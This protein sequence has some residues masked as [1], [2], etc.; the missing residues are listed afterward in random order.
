M[1][2]SALRPG[3]EHA[4]PRGP[5]LAV[6]AAPPAAPIARTAVPAAAG[7]EVVFTFSY[8]SWQAAA[9]RGWFMP[10][11][12]LA[13]ALVSHERVERVLIADLMRSL[14]A[15]LVR[16]AVSRARGDSHPFPAREGVR[17]ASPVRLRRAYPVS[18]P[19]VERAC[20]RYERALRRNAV[21]MGM[22]RPAVITANPLLA[23]FGR[24]EWA[25][26]VTFFA[27]DDWLAYP[28]HERWWPAYEESF[29]LVR[30]RGR[31]VC[32]VTP[33]A[34]ERISP[35]GP[36][37]VVP[38]GLDP[39]EWEGPAGAPPAWAREA[40]RPLLLYVGSLD[41]RLDIPALGA[42]A[43]ALPDAEIALVGPLLDEAHL[44]PLA[45]HANVSI[46]PP[47]GREEVAA[48]IRHADVGLIPHVSSEL[49][50]A[51]SPLKL[52]EY[53][54]GGLP[55]VAADLGPV[56]GVSEGVTLVPPGGGYA[57]G[58]K[59]ALGR[60]RSAEEE[61]LAFIAANSWRARQDD[62]LELALA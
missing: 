41:S 39:Q 27:T 51:M 46:H 34:L 8:V 5:R 2:D 45:A 57:K 62:L 24:F 43:A 48:L 9:A 29:R 17:L 37:L 44:A 28:P 36:A 26:P 25:G 30:A 6:A 61:R 1:R 53:L 3:P 33:A 31:R 47:V 59:A 11:D 54:A 32:A 20:V 14:P 60:G 38:N 21:A 19:A 35:S 12:R 7:A 40:R 4:G 50:R 56:R 42:L 18:L 23:G 10:E 58:A 16:D 52:Y 13:R 49:T 15:K 55:V 22:R